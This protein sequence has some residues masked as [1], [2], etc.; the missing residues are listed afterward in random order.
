MRWFA[1]LPVCCFIII[2]L[3]RYNY[4]AFFLLFFFP[5][6]FFPTANNPLQP[7]FTCCLLFIT[8]NTFFLF[9]QRKTSQRRTGGNVALS[10]WARGEK[11]EWNKTIVSMHSRHQYSSYQDGYLP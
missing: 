11:E 8:P 1:C 5:F 3:Y 2:A 7:L 9:L 6:S 4:S 10:Y